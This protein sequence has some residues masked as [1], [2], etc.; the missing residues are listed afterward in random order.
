[1]K[2]KKSIFALTALTICF[3]FLPYK[4]ISKAE[5]IN[6]SN[7]FENIETISSNDLIK[8]K[9][10]LIKDGID[11]DT[12]NKLIDKLKNGEVWDS[13]KPEFQNLKP[14]VK[15]SNYSKTIYPDGS[16]NIETIEDI[17]NFS[18][19]AIHRVKSRKVSKYMGIVN[20]SFYVDYERNT[21]TGKGRITSQYNY[22]VQIV[23]GN[24]SEDTKG[25]KLGWANPTNAWYAIN[26]QGYNNIFSGRYWIKIFVNGHGDWTSSNY[27]GY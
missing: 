18:P 23:G 2:I 24:Y 19:R 11:E 16:Y 1:M 13:M 6:Q 12:S 21:S 27:P 20:M 4:Q 7:Q 10:T 25:Y 15:T 8:L 3:S 22:N 5:E 14:Q 26:V 9:D 17:P